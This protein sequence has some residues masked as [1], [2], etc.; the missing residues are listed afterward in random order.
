[1][2]KH[3]LL[4]DTKIHKALKTFTQ[5]KYKLA[6]SN[7]LYSAI[8]KSFNKDNTLFSFLILCIYVNKKKDDYDVLL[9]FFNKKNEPSENLKWRNNK[10]LVNL[11]QSS[12]INKDFDSEITV[13]EPISDVNFSDEYL[14]ELLKVLPQSFIK[15][16]QEVIIYD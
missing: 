2:V 5:S 9:A 13:N 4:L 12:E 7:K 15:N 6:E 16:F 3:E 11:I 8:Y 14:N 1:M 10:Q